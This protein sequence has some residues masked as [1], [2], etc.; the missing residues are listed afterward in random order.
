MQRVANEEVAEQA[1]DWIVWFASGDAH[2]ADLD[3]FHQWLSISPLHAEA[4]DEA[5]SLWHALTPLESTFR[6]PAGPVGTM[7][8]RT[9]TNRIKPARRPR[10]VAAFGVAAVLLMM[11]V[12][13]HVW[14]RAQ[15][16]YMTDGDTTADVL[17]PDGSRVML[18]RY[19]AIRLAFTN[20]ERRVELL[21]GEALFNVQKDLRRPFRVVADGGVS[22]AVG[23]VYAVRLADNGV[24]VVVDEGRVRVVLDSNAANR[25]ELVPNEMLTYADDAFVKPPTHVDV[26]R[27]LAWR[28]GLLVFK[29]KPLAAVM[30]ELERYHPG[31]I[32][33]IGDVGG[34]QPVS[35]RVDLGRLDEGIATLAATH[36]LRVQHITP[37]LTVVRK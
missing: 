18:N 4:F 31:R 23:T 37:W 32:V 30:A 10:I 27:A 26:D 6:K 28:D 35:G 8:L 3:A 29:D 1:R 22:E 19:A 17:L 14:L 2:Q 7:E 13:P 12:G 33:V 20:T 15:A 36:G 5:K 9:R 34:F 11:L 24:R 16:D 25:I 21:R